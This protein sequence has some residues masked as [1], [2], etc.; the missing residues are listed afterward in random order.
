M[1][2][3]RYN[4]NKRPWG[5]LSWPALAVLVDVLAFGAKKYAAWNWSKGLSWTETF[6]S[7]QRHLVAWYSG[8][9]VDPETGIS[10]MGH[11]LCNAMFLMHFILF[12]TGVD[13]RPEDLHKEVTIE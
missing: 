6:E 1:A 13:D 4:S 3:L 11:V 9:D 12:K 5:L 7:M 8:E 2:G 10:H